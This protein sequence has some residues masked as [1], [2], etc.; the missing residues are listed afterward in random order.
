MVYFLKDNNVAASEK[1]DVYKDEETGEILAVSFRGRKLYI[2]PF[3][4]CGLGEDETAAARVLA[5]MKKYVDGGE[6]VYPLRY[7][8]EDAYTANLMTTAA[9][10]SWQPQKSQNRPW[11]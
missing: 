7:A 9:G 10:N 11:K 3:G 1:M 4:I 5:G 6:E 8:L 2:P